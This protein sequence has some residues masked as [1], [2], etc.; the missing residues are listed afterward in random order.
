[1]GAYWRSEYEDETIVDKA[2]E[3]YEEILPLYK[4]LHAYVRRIMHNKHRARVDVKG[5][6]P[7][8]LL[9]RPIVNFTFLSSIF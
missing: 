8:N 1:M 9:G 4:Q 3:L 5:R 6:I 7:S 2:Y